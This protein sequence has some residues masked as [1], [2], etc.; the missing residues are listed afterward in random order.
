MPKEPHRV[1][2]YAD[3]DSADWMDAALHLAAVRYPSS[4]IVVRN[5]Q[6]YRTC[7]REPA[8]VIVIQQR[9]GNVIADY[10]GATV[11]TEPD[12]YA[13]PVHIEPAPKRKRA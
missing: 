4:R 13:P 2:V 5:Q 7:D 3:N 10:A 11:L 9:W 12:V 6:A 1:I 8:D